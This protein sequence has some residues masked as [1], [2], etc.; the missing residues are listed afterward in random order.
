M[1]SKLVDL[2]GSKTKT[3][4]E[5]TEAHA[6]ICVKKEKKK[7]IKQTQRQ[8]KFTSTKQHITTK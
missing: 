7:I 3:L 1:I 4:R 6:S 8:I 5:N 2:A